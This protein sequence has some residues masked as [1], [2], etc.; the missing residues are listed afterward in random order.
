[1]FVSPSGIAPGVAGTRDCA[2]RGKRAFPVS[3]T[4]ETGQDQLVSD[5]VFDRDSVKA[6]VPGFHR[7]FFLRFLRSLRAFCLGVTG[8]TSPPIS[9][10]L[11]TDSFQ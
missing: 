9:E 8:F 10:T 2:P 6:A 3:R 11:A 5:S 1:M 7:A 4:V